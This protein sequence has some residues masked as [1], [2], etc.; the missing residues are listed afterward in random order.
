MWFY[1]AVIS[2]GEVAAKLE[3]MPED[4]ETDLKKVRKEIIASLEGFDLRN[5]EEEDIAF[6]LKKL[7]L[8]V[9]VADEEGGTDEIEERVQGIDGVES[10]SVEDVNRLM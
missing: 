10:V 5:A 8:T 2:V 3:V 6:G 4:A 9:V 7:I 1:W